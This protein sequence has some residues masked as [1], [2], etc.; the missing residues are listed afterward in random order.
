MDLVVSLSV[1]FLLATVITI[2]LAQ[3]RLRRARLAFLAGLFI[4]GTTK[5]RFGHPTLR[6]LD[7][8]D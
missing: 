5:L 8:E 7:P 2:R 3:Y 4:G 1:L 6:F